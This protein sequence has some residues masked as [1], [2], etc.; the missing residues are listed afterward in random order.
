MFEDIGLCAGS[1]PVLLLGGDPSLL[2]NHYCGFKMGSRIIGCSNVLIGRRRVLDLRGNWCWNY[3]RDFIHWNARRWN[4]FLGT[5]IEHGGVGVG[6]IGCFGFLLLGFLDLHILGD[7]GSVN[8][9]DRRINGGIRRGLRGIILDV[10]DLDGISGASLGPVHSKV[11]I[12][13]GI[14]VDL[15]LILSL[16]D[17]M[18]ILVFSFSLILWSQEI[19][20]S[21]FI[22]FGILI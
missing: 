12:D 6:S 11:I 13:D 19:L 10:L 7:H 15:L 9:L 1:L 22:I 2:N 21:R 20:F 4:Y 3:F 16:A 17:I 14:L 8:D 18:A 5:F